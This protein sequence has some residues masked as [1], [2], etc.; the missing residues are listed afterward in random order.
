MNEALQDA[1]SL[2]IKFLH[3]AEEMLSAPLQTS[4][5]ESNDL[6]KDHYS[7]LAMK[8][9]GKRPQSLHTLI[10]QKQLDFPKLIEDI[11]QKIKDPSIKEHAVETA[12]RLINKTAT[13]EVIHKVMG[14]LEEISNHRSI[15][16][17]DTVSDFFAPLEQ[18]K[19]LFV[20]SRH[21][22]DSD[23]ILLQKYC[24][25]FIAVSTKAIMMKWKAAY[26][27]GNFLDMDHAFFYQYKNVVSHLNSYKA[28]LLALHP[29]VLDDSAIDHNINKRIDKPEAYKNFSSV[30]FIFGALPDIDNLS[31]GELNEYAAKL[32]NLFDYANAR[33]Q[34]WSTL[35]AL[36]NKQKTTPKTKPQK[37]SFTYPWTIESRGAITHDNREPDD[38]LV[39]RNM[40]P[41]GDDGVDLKTKPIPS[42]TRATIKEVG[43]AVSNLMNYLDS[44]MNLRNEFLAEFKLFEK[45][46]HNGPRLDRLRYD[47]V[48][49]GELPRH[50]RK[51][52]IAIDR[53]DMTVATFLDEPES[54]TF[55]FQQRTV[56]MIAAFTRFSNVLREYSNNALP[57]SPAP[58][59]NLKK[60]EDS[61]QL[62]LSKIANNM[63]QLFDAMD[64]PII[65]PTLSEP[66][67]DRPKKLVTTLAQHRQQERLAYTPSMFRQ[68]GVGKSRE[69]TVYISLLPIF[70]KPAFP[71]TIG[72]IA[73]K[74]NPLAT[75]CSVLETLQNLAEQMSNILN[76]VEPDCC[77]AYSSGKHRAPSLKARSKRHSSKTNLRASSPETDDDNSSDFESSKEA[78]FSSFSFSSSSSSNAKS[79]SSSSYSSNS[80]YS[81]N[82]SSDSSLSSPTETKL[83]TDS[84]STAPNSARLNADQMNPLLLATHKT[85]NISD[86]NA[87]DK[88]SQ[89]DNHLSQI[90]PDKIRSAKPKELA[91]LVRKYTSL[92]WSLDS[93]LHDPIGS[94][95]KVLGPV[96]IQYN[97]EGMLYNRE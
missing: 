4:F 78:S 68:E 34:S 9:G 27:R 50:V 47:N 23:R 79:T 87:D 46:N 54:I 11:E 96:T 39:Y 82:Y 89:L 42:E 41:E 73:A 32:L 21:L 52:T 17:K 75:S 91:E 71:E 86:S 65:S 18:L 92:A 77:S 1:L 72:I 60:A 24:L 48:S 13:H 5:D 8:S 80:S 26:S 15:T 40:N 66:M 6:I 93:A 31:T 7:Q 20:N 19:N 57:A 70:K 14:Y 43:K 53:S 55:R 90:T 85:L 64:W 25:L 84:V 59:L 29:I 16:I 69:R 37:Q 81:Y 35:P 58:R 49:V 10:A 76:R 38:L 62:Q 88:K 2:A 33:L 12:T 67:P 36:E 22:D 44:L 28:H 61:T 95:S 97:D 94:F 30:D 56:N 3:N 74:K 45:Y 83:E 63:M 51:K